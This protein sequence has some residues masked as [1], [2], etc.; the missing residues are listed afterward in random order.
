MKAI[1][2]LL[3]LT[4]ILSVGSGAAGQSISGQNPVLRDHRITWPLAFELDGIGPTIDVGN[5]PRLN[6]STFTISAY[7]KFKELNQG[8][9]LFV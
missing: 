1:R 7:V 4:S 3:L 6:T 9:Q 5:R 8:S 2:L